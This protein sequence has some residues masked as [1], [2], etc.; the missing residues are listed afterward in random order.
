[1]NYHYHMKMPLEKARI[2]L[3]C[4]TIHDLAAC[5]ECGSASFYYLANWIKPR[6]PPRPEREK[7]LFELPPPKKKRHWVRNGLMAAASIVAAYQLLFKP[8]RRKKQD[9]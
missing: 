1:M 6:H 4:D 2:C 9:E 5:P 8:S 3:E 7:P